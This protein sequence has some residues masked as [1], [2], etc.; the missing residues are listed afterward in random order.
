MWFRSQLFKPSG[1]CRWVLRKKFA[2]SKYFTLLQSYVASICL[3]SHVDLFKPFRE[4]KK[5]ILMFSQLI[6]AKYTDEIYRSVLL[7]VMQPM[8]LAKAVWGTACL[9]WV[10]C[11]CSCH[12]VCINCSTWCTASVMPHFLSKITTWY[13]VM[14]VLKG[15]N[16]YQSLSNVLDQ[17]LTLSHNVF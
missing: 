12:V 10:V 13:E 9:T 11:H 8:N 1:E 5:V 4:W 3:Q 6:H 17:C 15:E 7:T 14:T 16:I 2:I